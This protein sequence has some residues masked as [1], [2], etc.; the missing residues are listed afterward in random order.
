MMAMQMNI[1]VN[2]TSVNDDH[3]IFFLW[4]MSLLTWHCHAVLML[5]GL[6]SKP[7]NQL[8]RNRRGHGWRHQWHSYWRSSGG[9]G[10]SHHQIIQI[11]HEQCQEQCQCDAWFGATV[12]T[13]CKFDHCLPLDHQAQEGSNSVCVIHWYSHE[14]KT[15]M[16]LQMKCRRSKTKHGIGKLRSQKEDTG[17][18]SNKHTY[19]FICMWVLYVCVNMHVWQY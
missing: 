19:I 14:W 12:L 15:S 18:C 6:A 16:Y 3:G 13:T 9:Q 4:H 7:H 10:T 8:H 2:R 11:R 5:P 17:T 1:I